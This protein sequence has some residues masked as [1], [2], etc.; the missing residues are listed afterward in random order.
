MRRVLSLVALCCLVCCS[1]AYSAPP[2]SKQAYLER[3]HAIINKHKVS[4]G[5]AVIQPDT[6][7]TLLVSASKHFPM[8]SVFKFHLA[9][10]ILDKVDQGKYALTDSML[11]RKSDMHP[12]WWSPLREKYG[13]RDVAL[14][15]EEILHATVASSDNNGCDFLFEKLGGPHVLN[16]HLHRKGIRDIAIVIN[17]AIMQ[18][19]WER[20]YENWTTASAA[21]QTLLLTF[22][23]KTMLS[24]Q[25]TEYL[26]RT[27]VGTTTGLNKLKALLPTGTVVAHKTGW[28]GAKDGLTAA[29]NDIGI[30]ELPNKQHIAIAVF[31][32]ES[33]ENEDT[34]CRIIAEISKVVWDYYTTR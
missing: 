27:M 16:E 3:I 33:R 24:P 6:R 5:V 10:G 19:H 2:M 17:E 7:D 26:W 8:Q 34:N 11:M 9:L 1:G 15:L 28:S 31:V 21:V 30:I 25:S 32:G 4:V 18:A 29:S 23:N 20:Q 13:E 22:H 14:P 12:N